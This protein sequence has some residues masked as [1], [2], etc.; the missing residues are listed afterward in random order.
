MKSWFVRFALVLAIPFLQSCTKGSQDK[1]AGE[2]GSSGSSDVIKV[3]EIGSMT[4]SEATF[5][6]STHEGVEL[7]V[8]EINAQGGLLGKKIVVVKYDNQG[9]PEEAAMAMNKL[10]TQDKVV[11]VIGEV[12]SSR[13]L[14]M[15]PIAQSNKIPMISPSST[16][17]KVTQ[18]GDYIFRVCFIDP[19]QGEVMA[20]FAANQLKVKK[21][22]VLRD[23]KNDYSVGLSDIFTKKFQEMGGQVV[24]DQSY[25][26]GDLD[27]KAQLTSIRGKAPEAIYIPGYYTEVGLIARQARDLGLKVPLLGGDGWDSPKL[28]EIGQKSIEGSFISNHYSTEDKSENIQTFVKKYQDAYKRVPDSLAAMGYD[29]MLVLADAIKRAGT[30]ESTKLRDAIAST[31]DLQV[32]TGKITLGADRNP[33]KAAVILKVEDGKFKYQSTIEP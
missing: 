29:A 4:G 28:F 21:V 22:A 18:Q 24:I 30:T 1:N 15:A 25:S 13:S 6:T 31:K 27:F 32:V 23:V 5:G 9:K 2:A 16:N 12:A 8:K 33:I 19:F 3:G 7:A 11:A 14:A 17:P 10:I 26:Q 20:K